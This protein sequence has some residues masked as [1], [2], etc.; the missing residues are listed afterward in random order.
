MFG[1]W[2]ANAIRRHAEA[3][4]PREACGV[5]L[6]EGGYLPLTNVHR[7]PRKAFRLPAEGAEMV[8]AGVVDAVVHSHTGD[9]YDHPSAADLEDQI[10]CGPPI[11]GLVIV[12]DGIAGK[13]FFWGNGIPEVPYEER[14][15]RW[16]PTG[17]D[18]AGDCYAL[19]RDWYRRER[20]LILPEAPRD[21]RWEI[22]S[23]DLYEIG[24]RRAGFRPV[25][26]D[27]IRAGDGLLMRLATRN[28]SPN[29]AAIALGN[30]Q[31]LHHRRGRLSGTESIGRWIERLTHCLRPPEPA[32]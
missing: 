28:S 1:A 21:C 7:R 25:P 26:I 2:V 6:K 13:P 32:A 16:G 9:G 4:A 15:Y 30:G 29:H 5:V 10:R 18:G 27:D 12:R 19:A 11:W 22:E 8:A 14:V 24:W 23:P 20:G 3:E 17:T 31:I